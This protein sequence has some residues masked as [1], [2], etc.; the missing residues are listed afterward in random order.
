MPRLSLSL[1]AIVP[2]LYISLSVAQGLQQLPGLKYVSV[3]CK[4]A[5]GSA[6]S[7]QIVSRNGV[8]SS[9]CTYT[10]GCLNDSG[11][12]SEI[13]FTV[14]SVTGDPAGGSCLSFQHYIGAYDTARYK[15]SRLISPFPPPPTV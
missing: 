8:V 9:Q 7:T 12:L 5:A 11:T 6:K 10:C 4:P 15:C 13:Q 14:I 3:L 2:L 1:L